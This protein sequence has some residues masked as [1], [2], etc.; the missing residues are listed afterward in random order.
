[1]GIAHHIAADGGRCPPYWLAYG[2]TPPTQHVSQ[3]KSLTDLHGAISLEI[4]A[5]SCALL[6]ALLVGGEGFLL[7]A[8]ALSRNTHD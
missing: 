2:T 3:D 7:V 4:E 1:M 8:I 5:L 6:V